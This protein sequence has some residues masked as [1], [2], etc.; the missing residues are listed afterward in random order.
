MNN[1]HLNE[2]SNNEI[3]KNNSFSTKTIKNIKDEYNAKLNNIKQNEELRFSAILNSFEISKEASSYDENSNNTYCD[4]FN[5]FYNILI[6][7]KKEQA[8]KQSNYEEVPNQI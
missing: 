6:A 5:S 2:S 7:E 3:T 4:Y 8:E 1:K